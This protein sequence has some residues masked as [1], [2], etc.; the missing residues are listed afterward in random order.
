VL[1]DKMEQLQALNKP[2]FATVSP[3]KSD[4]AADNENADNGNTFFAK[5]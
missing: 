3:Y 5:H 4:A 1:R 2:L